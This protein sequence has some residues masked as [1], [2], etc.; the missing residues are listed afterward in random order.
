MKHQKGATLITVLIILV[1]ITLIGTIAVKSGILGLKIATNSQVNSL[2]MGN[3]DSALFNIEN[4]NQV[5]RQMAFDGMFA[6]FDSSDN[7]KDELVFC[8]RATESVFFQLSKAS[9]ITPSGST[10]K[11]G[12]SGF[13]K[14]NQFSMGRSAVI[15]QVYLTKNATS[16]VPFS[17][18]PKGTSIGQSPVPSSTNSIGA[19]VISILPSFSAASKTAIEACFKKRSS[20]V[21][22]CFD[23][24]NIPYNMQHSDYIVGGQPKLVS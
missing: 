21:A 23:G 20:E 12:V 6:Y 24:L 22:A 5:A 14:A 18:V 2:L 8:Y 11:Q 13:C 3:S 4:P 19:S 1:V 9:A 17:S 15:S 16:E 10:T 7:A